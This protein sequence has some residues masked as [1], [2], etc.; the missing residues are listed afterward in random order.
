MTATEQMTRDEFYEKFPWVFS[1]P[2]H[3]QCNECFSVSCYVV[4]DDWLLLSESHTESCSR[5]SGV[6]TPVYKT[7]KVSE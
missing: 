2:E 5:K 1:M 6:E 3:P 7:Q 4:R